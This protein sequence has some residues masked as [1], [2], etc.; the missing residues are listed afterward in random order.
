MSLL[1]D[2]RLLLKKHGIKPS[3]RLGQNFLVDRDVLLREISYADVKNT[4]T[5]LEI[6]PGIG[7]LTELLVKNAK[8]LLAPRA[9]HSAPCIQY[10]LARR[11]PSAFSLQSFV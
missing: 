7:T 3:K 6:G 11:S 4:D 5:I 1:E 9:L 8:K 10:L 2:T